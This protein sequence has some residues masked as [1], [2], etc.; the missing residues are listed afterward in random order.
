MWI[1][2]VEHAGQ[3]VV[4]GPDGGEHCDSKRTGRQLLGMYSSLLTYINVS[5]IRSM[6]CV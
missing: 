4:D 3:L 5:Y 6:T 1:A 2:A